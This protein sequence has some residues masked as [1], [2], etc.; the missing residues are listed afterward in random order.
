[1]SDE[2]LKSVGARNQ[3]AFECVII[4]TRTIRLFNLKIFL[5]L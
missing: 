4:G 5:I 1:M 3:R 2:V